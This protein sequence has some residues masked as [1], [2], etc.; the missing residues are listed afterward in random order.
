[1]L[2]EF[3][4][5]AIKGNMLDMAVGIVIGAAFSAIVSSMVDDIIMPPIG[6]IL[7]NVDFSELFLVLKQGMPEGP[8][9]TVDAA[10][11]AGAVTWNLGL[12]VNAMVKFTIVAFALFIVVKGVNRLRREEKAKPAEPAKPPRQE[13][14]L[15]EIRDLLKK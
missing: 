14:L 1:M 10:K 4:E 6:L 5:F 7:G 8:Y 2:K 3:K 13:L 11:A 12:F 9:P 15:E